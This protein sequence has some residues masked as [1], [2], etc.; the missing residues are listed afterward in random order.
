MYDL[1]VIYAGDHA[2]V[3][4]AQMM[5][6]ALPSKINIVSKSTS[7][8]IIMFGYRA[9]LAICC[10]KKLL[11]L[12]R[13][14]AL[15][16]L[17]CY[18]IFCWW[19]RAARPHIIYDMWEFYTLKEHKK[20]TSRLG[21]LVEIFVLK[22]VN[23]VI[24]CNAHR[25]TLIRR[26]YGIE[27]ADVI[28]NIRAL[29][30]EEISDVN[31][32][33]KYLSH[34]SWSAVNFVITNGFSSERG[35]TNLIE[36]FANQY[37][38]SLTFI[39][40]STAADEVLLEE[41]ISKKGLSNIYKVNTIPYAILAGVVKFFDFGV[42]N[43]SLRNLNNKYCASGKVYEFMFLGLPVLTSSNPSLKQVTDHY[44]CGES[45]NEL[46]TGISRLVTNCTKHQSA[47]RNI[48]LD[49]LLTSHRDHIVDVILGED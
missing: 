45:T 43:Y 19:H 6:S 15:V 18:P 40:R 4:R 38:Y 39:G 37:N 7:P 29:P 5:T 27:N 16:F 11:I 44:H 13:K 23:K 2:A 3:G 8:N 22:R 36:A 33:E 12:S 31:L 17:L 1:S 47:L 24:V 34:I 46:S 35:D 14:S 20:L 9:L 28:E 10:S 25:K 26:Y 48:E 32:K 41:L 49:Q 30:Y 42:V 21:T